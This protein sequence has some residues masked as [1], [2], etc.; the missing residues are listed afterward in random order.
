MK[1][2]IDF[3]NTYGTSIIHSISIA[4]IS[5]VSLEIKKIYKNHTED[6]IK[7]E[8]IKMVCS[9]ID[10]IYPNLNNENKLNKIITNSKQI[11]K[12]KGILINDLE[13]RIYI[14]TYLRSDK[15]WV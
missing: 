9:T 15:L 5:Y 12:E 1:Y 8:V 7:K 6:K 10:Q 14:E 2:I 11:L 4:I 13:L 3:L